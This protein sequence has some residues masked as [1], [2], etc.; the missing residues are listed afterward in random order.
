MAQPQP[1]PVGPTQME[2]GLGSGATG[3]PG[4]ELWDS[5]AVRAERLWHVGTQCWAVQGMSWGSH[6]SAHACE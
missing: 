6:L 5:W 3:T 2:P 1:P 4:V